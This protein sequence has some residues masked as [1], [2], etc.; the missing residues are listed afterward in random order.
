MGQLNMITVGEST[1]LPEHR[2]GRPIAVRGQLVAEL[3]DER[4]HEVL[5]HHDSASHAVTISIREPGEDGEKGGWTCTGYTGHER[6]TDTYP[7]AL[8]QWLGERFTANDQ[9]Q[10]AAA[11]SRD[12]LDA[13]RECTR[14]WEENLT[15]LRESGE[16]MTDEVYE[17]C[18]R[19]RTG[20][21]IAQRATARLARQ[22]TGSFSVRMDRQ[23]EDLKENGVLRTM[24]E[25]LGVYTG[26][27]REGE[28]DEDAMPGVHALAV[29]LETPNLM[30]EL[31]LNPGAED[32][33]HA[34]AFAIGCEMGLGGMTGSIALDC[35]LSHPKALTMRVPGLGKEQASLL[36]HAVHAPRPDFETIRIVARYA[37][38]TTGEL[39]EEIASGVHGP[40]AAKAMRWAREAV[41]VPYMTPI[42]GYRARPDRA[43]P[44]TRWN[45]VEVTIHPDLLRSELDRIAEA[46]S[47]CAEHAEQHRGWPQVMEVK[48]AIGRLIALGEGIDTG[49]ATPCEEAMRTVRR[50]MEQHKA[51]HELPEERFVRELETRDRTPA[52]TLV[53]LDRV[54]GEW[55]GWYGHESDGTAREAV[56]DDGGI[57]EWTGEPT[58]GAMYARQ[59]ARAGE[60]P[61]PQPQAGAG[62]EG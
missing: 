53:R 10:P 1:W 28:P 58:P 2:T 17:R 3:R 39:A 60:K 46:R 18:D 26:E 59:A 6:L 7:G 16:P 21:E 23:M 24:I 61:R 36:E 41:R 45:K 35:A 8:G 13:L 32:R 4:G 34:R 49:E 56:A 12:K 37:K 9:G 43:D 20:I 57:G 52:Q 15:W 27:P 30:R 33:E 11:P 50:S 40:V 38:Q 14:R 19:L 5:V 48:D 42:D 54:L 62:I 29:L 25:D 44:A 47:R 55:K 51:G 31:A 22:P